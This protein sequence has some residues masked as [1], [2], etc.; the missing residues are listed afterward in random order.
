MRVRMPKRARRL[1]TWFPVSHRD[2]WENIGLVKTFY[3]MK[4][5]K[6]YR[7]FVYQAGGKKLE[8]K[9]GISNK[10]SGNLF[11]IYPFFLFYPWHWFSYW[12]LESMLV[13]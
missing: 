11:A 3:S 7:V 6:W 5:L 12:N 2:A 8:D 1:L 10:G 4:A 13:K 9:A